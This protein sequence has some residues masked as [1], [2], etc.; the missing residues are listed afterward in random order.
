MESKEKR[1]VELVEENFEIM[2]QGS[3]IQ[4]HKDIPA[5]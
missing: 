2:N 1:R 5:N 4:W 3:L